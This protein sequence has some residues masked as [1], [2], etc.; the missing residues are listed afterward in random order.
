MRIVA[1]SPRVADALVEAVQA[2]LKMEL[3]FVSSTEFM[4]DQQKTE[5]IKLLLDSAHNQEKRYRSRGNFHVVSGTSFTHCVSCDLYL[6]IRLW[7]SVD[8]LI[9]YA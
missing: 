7:K 2:M 3:D 8:L 4:H 5:R 6:L 1:K 9:F